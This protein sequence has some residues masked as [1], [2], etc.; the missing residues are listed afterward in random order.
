MALAALIIKASLGLTDA[1]L[2]EQ[3]TPPCHH[4]HYPKVICADQIY[5]TDRTLP[6]VSAMESAG[7]T[8]VWE[9][10]GMI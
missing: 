9:D 5:R 3:V 6:S 8:R 2:V 7:V 4:A 10:Q 1:E